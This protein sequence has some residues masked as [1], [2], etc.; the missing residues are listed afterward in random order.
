MQALKYVFYGWL[1][2]GLA[3]TALAAGPG[4]GLRRGEAE[5][6]GLDPVKITA[7]IHMVEQETASGAV[8]AAALLVARNGFVAVERG[9]GRLSRDPASPRCRPDSVFIVASISKPITTLAVMRLVDQGRLRLDDPVAKY[10]PGF[11]G[12]FRARITIRNLLTHTSG[13][14]DNIALRRRHAPLTDFAA[15]ALQTPLLF[16]PGTQ[17]SYSSMGILLAAT[18]VERVSGQPLDAFLHQEVFAPLGMTHSSMGLGS[19]RIAD[20]VQCDLPAHGDLIMT[21]ADRSWDWNSP[22]WRALGSPWG[23]L[24]TTTGDIALALQAMLDAGRPVLRP[25]TAR[26]MITDQNAGLNK[27]WGLGWTLGADASYDGSPAG[28]FGHGGASGTLCWADPA[29]K[30]IFV[31]FTNRPN[32]NDPSHFLRRVSAVVSEAAP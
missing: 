24:H 31:L 15:E 26:A 10:L 17:Q 9:Y 8:G 2:L 21:D 25:E 14:P 32:V 4:A 29:R 3:A 22:Y 5:K 30:L 18:I 12:D 27:P 28:V 19:R 20:T 23:G 1:C 11:T 6:A 7:A 13:L 16:A